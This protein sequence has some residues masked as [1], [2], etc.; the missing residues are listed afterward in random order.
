MSEDI[1]AHIWGR[2]S[3]LTVAWLNK[4]KEQLTKGASVYA[5]VSG[6][7]MARHLKRLAEENGLM[8]NV[9]CEIQKGRDPVSHKSRRLMWLE[10]RK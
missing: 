7:I 6:K 1:I 9:R 5:P 2:R 3:G 10:I 4:V 8:A